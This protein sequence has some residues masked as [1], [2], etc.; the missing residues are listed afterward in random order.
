M[1]DFDKKDEG[2]R[3]FRYSANPVSR[4]FGVLGEGGN[5]LDVKAI[6]VLGD[7]Y[8]MGSKVVAMTSRMVTWC[9]PKGNLNIKIIH[10]INDCQ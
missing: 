6:P 10:I 3:R 7:T 9:P 8:V 2:L 1:E 4:S 5:R